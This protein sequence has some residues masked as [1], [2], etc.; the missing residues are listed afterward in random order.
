MQ[1]LQIVARNCFGYP[2]FWT[3]LTTERPRMAVALLE[4][5]KNTPLDLTVTVPLP[6][7]TGFKPSTRPC[8]LLLS[9]LP[10][11]RTLDLLAIKDHAKEALQLLAQPAPL[12]QYLCAAWEPDEVHMPKYPHT[13]CDDH[14]A[15][16]S[17]CGFLIALCRT[18]RNRAREK[19]QPATGASGPDL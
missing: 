4:R 6:R 13:Y 16:D 10:R 18:M 2:D 8:R 9:A 12:L 1:C 19:S 14:V 17:Y 15:R 3:Y 5:T 11:E 7:C